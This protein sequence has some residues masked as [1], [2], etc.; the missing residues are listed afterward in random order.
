MARLPAAALSRH[1]LFRSLLLRQPSSTRV[2]VLCALLH[3]FRLKSM[4][5]QAFNT[6]SL[7]SPSSMTENTPFLVLRD[8]E[9]DTSLI[10]TEWHVAPSIRCQTYDTDVPRRYSAPCRP[11]LSSLSVHGCK[12]MFWKDCMHLKRCVCLDIC[13]TMLGDGDLLPLI[14]VRSY[15]NTI[16]KMHLTWK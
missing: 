7:Y 14:V 9:V 13:G 6:T 16:R 5:L 15:P 2:R 11:Q 12:W 4:T 3:Q 1:V 8:I 10:I